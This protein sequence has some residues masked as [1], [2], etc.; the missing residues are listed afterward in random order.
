MVMVALMNSKK[1]RKLRQAIKDQ[2][3]NKSDIA[4]KIAYKIAKK[5]FNKRKK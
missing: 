3:E 4:L 2:S 1:A 5:E